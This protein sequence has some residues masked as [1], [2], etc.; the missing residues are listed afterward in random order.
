MAN[1]RLNGLIRSAAAGAALLSMSLMLSGCVNNTPLDDLE[2]V[3]PTDETSAFNKALFTNYG[4]LARS[5]GDVGQASHSVFD[6]SGSLSLNDTDNA[7]AVLVNGFASKAVSAAKDEFIDPEPARN[8]TAHDMRDRLMRALEIGRDGFPRDAARAQADYDC[9]MLNSDVPSQKPAAEQCRLSLETTL[10]LAETEAKI[11]P[12]TEAKP[13]PKTAAAETPD[14]PKAAKTPKAPKAA[15]PAAPP[16]GAQ[17]AQPP[18]PPAIEPPAPR[19]EAAN[20]TFTVYFDFDSWTLVAEQLKVLDDAAKAAR[21]GTA[22]KIRIVGHTDTSGPA[23]YN[24]HL[25]LRRANV[26]KEALIGMGVRKSAIKTGGVGE[27]DLAVETGDNVR[28][29]KN[30]RSIVNV[31]Q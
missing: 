31:S 30:R 5:F 23:G 11:A 27:A 18:A 16:A 4:F 28:E 6:F 2:Y 13:A 1:F 21:D 20:E 22:V 3:K 19:P 10:P 24:R 26:V 17:P 12:P 15:K 14:A 9:W 7:V 29:P 25:S 8:P